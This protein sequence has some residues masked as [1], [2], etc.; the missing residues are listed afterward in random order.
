MTRN[1]GA[2]ARCLECLAFLA[3]GDECTEASSAACRHAARL[4]GAAA[5]LRQ[6]HAAPMAVY[7]ADEYRTRRDALQARLG[8]QAFAAE[9]ASAQAFTLE[10]AIALALRDF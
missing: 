10:Q 6:R 8:D 9:W 1:P 3:T 7:E 4:L 5:A 2:I